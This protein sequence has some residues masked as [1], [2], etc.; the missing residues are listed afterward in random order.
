MALEA[1]NLGVKIE[2]HRILTGVNAVFSDGKRTSII[3]PNGAGKSTLLKAL[4]G[5]NTDYEGMVLLDGEDIRA[6]GRGALSKKLA[7]LPQGATAPADV[8][9][10]QLVDFGRFPYRSWFR[11]GDPK[12]DREAV[13]W[14]LDRTRMT[15]FKDRRVSVLSGG[16]RQRAWIA[17]ALAQKPKV[18]LLDEPTTY[19]DIGHQLEVMN[20]VD[21]INR[22]YKMTVVMVLH[23]IN[24]AL[25][26]SDEIVVIK[27]RGVYAHGAPREILTVE[28]IA[29][30]FGVK[31]DIF[32]NS[33]GISV[34]SPLSLAD[35]GED[36]REKS[37]SRAGDE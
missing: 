28:L 19:L 11:P 24:H 33:R 12:A 5:L 34:L 13:E 14:A 3:G 18:L 25:Q 6:M 30:V 29:E 2:G 31:A 32:V 7:I 16:E 22:D 27:D 4:S 8:T 23:D 10:G 17:M 35:E 21:E 20:I 37:L 9:V 36:G 26:Y 1:K 15:G